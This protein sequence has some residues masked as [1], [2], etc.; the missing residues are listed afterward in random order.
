MLHRCDQLDRSDPALGNR[1]TFYRV[2]T[3]FCRPRQ[4]TG[5]C[6]LCK[7][8]YLWQCRLDYFYN[9]VSH[10]FRCFA[11]NHDAQALEALSRAMQ[12]AATRLSESA[13]LL[14]LGW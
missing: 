14:R 4:Y 2:C 9:R 12:S 10:K 11:C 13:R 6:C 8:N 7:K 3:D 1:V 5:W